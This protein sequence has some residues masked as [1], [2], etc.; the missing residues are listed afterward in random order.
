MKQ[1]RG[2]RLLGVSVV[3]HLRISRTIQNAECANEV[4]TSEQ[5]NIHVLLFNILPGGHLSLKS[6]LRVQDV[7]ATDEK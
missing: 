5:T 2:A 7:V 1:S 3:E 4:T 6:T